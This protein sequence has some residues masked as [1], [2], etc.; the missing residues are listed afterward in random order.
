LVS[1][2]LLLLSSVSYAQN[3]KD[4]AVIDIDKMFKNE[5]YSIQNEG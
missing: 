2:M 5:P 4:D 3:V 1:L